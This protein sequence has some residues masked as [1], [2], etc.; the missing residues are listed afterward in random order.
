[1][2][3]CR[4]TQKYYTPTHIARDFQSVYFGSPSEDLL[5]ES[6]ACMGLSRGRRAPTDLS[7]AHQE[8]LRKL[9]DES[10][11]S[12]PMCV[13]SAWG[14]KGLLSCKIRV[15]LSSN[16]SMSIELVRMQ[17]ASTPYAGICT[18]APVPTRWAQSLANC[19][20]VSNYTACRTAVLTLSL[21]SSVGSRRQSLRILYSHSHF[22]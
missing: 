10:L 9:V 4:P 19:L 14:M 8:E 15:L 18:V 2:K 21:R 5:I 6:I 3:R 13:I 7:N 16:L 17:C 22:G 12:Q 1:M 11:V 20:R